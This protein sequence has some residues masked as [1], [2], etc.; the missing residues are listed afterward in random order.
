MTMKAVLLFSGAMLALTLAGCSG[1][2]YQPLEIK[3]VGLIPAAKIEKKLYGHADG[4]SLAFEGGGTWAYGSDSQELTAQ[5]FLTTQAKIGDTTFVAPQTLDTRFNFSIYDT[6]FRWRHFI[7]SGPIGYELA[8]GG[9]FSRLHVEASGNGMQGEETVYSPDLDFRIGVLVRLSRTT[10][11][12]ANSTLFYT[13][14][15]LSN[16]ARN[17]ISVVQMLGQ[18]VAVDGGYSWLYVDSPSTTRSTVKIQ[19]SGPSVGIRFVF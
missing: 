12:E 13:N 3:S 17:Q 7:K 19:A 1:T 2:V 5:P 15:K 4:K 9:G 11:V 16:V 8:G 6:S 10:R 14:S 18:H